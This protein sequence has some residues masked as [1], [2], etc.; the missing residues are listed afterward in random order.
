MFA[1]HK[2]RLSQPVT[3]KTKNVTCRWGAPYG[4]FHPLY[5]VQK[6]CLTARSKWGIRIDW[7]IS[8]Q[9]CEPHYSLRR[10]NEHAVASRSLLPPERCKEKRE[11]V[12]E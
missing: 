5:D 8:K 11:L 6:R 1:P 2:F 12:F 7:Y 3:R 4:F 9:S 10:D